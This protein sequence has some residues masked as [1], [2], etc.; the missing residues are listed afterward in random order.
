MRLRDLLLAFLLA[1][2]L[3]VPGF[4]KDIG[5]TVSCLGNK[6]VCVPVKCGPKMKQIG[7]CGSPKVKCC[8]RK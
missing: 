5:N 6:G 4:T 2:L 8:R 3:S 1:L 7:T